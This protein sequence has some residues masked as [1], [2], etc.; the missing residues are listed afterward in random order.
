MQTKMSTTKKMMRKNSFFKEFPL[1]EKMK[2]TPKTV[3]KVQFLDTPRIAE[4]AKR[5]KT[6]QTVNIH[7]R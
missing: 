3:G 4:K 5:R 2:A 1:Q 6:H 7:I